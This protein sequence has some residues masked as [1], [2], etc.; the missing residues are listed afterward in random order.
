MLYESFRTS[1]IMAFE[2]IRDQGATVKSRFLYYVCFT[3]FGNFKLWFL[4]KHAKLRHPRGFQSARLYEFSR[5]F[6]FMRNHRSLSP[7]SAFAIECHQ[8]QSASGFIFAFPT[9]KQYLSW[10]NSYI[11][12]ACIIRSRIIVVIF[13]HNEKLTKNWYNETFLM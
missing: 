1:E 12:W 2:L 3:R 13:C 10:R 8:M 4:Y 9:L 7:P 11:F 5:T 6:A